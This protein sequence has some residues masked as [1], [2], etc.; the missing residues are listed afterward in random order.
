MLTDLRRSHALARF[1]LATS[2]AA[3]A[4]FVPAA[5]AQESAALFD[6]PVIVS[7]HFHRFDQLLDLDGDGDSDA[8]GWWW[9][10]QGRA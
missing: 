10:P 4:A 2:A 7:D 1:L 3:L 5:R 9:L 8:V 6:A